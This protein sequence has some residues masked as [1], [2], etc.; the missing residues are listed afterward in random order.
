MMTKLERINLT[1][2]DD[3][4]TWKLDKSGKF[5]TRSMYRYITFAG[6]VDVR[7]MEIWNTKIPLKVKIFLWMAWHD[8]IQTAQ[9]FRRRN[10]DGSKVCKF[11]GKD[12]TVD[13]LLFQCS[14]A[15]VTWCCVRNSL[16]WS[17][18]PS[19]INNFQEVFLD[20]AGGN[21]NRFQW[22]VIAR[23][24]WAIWKTRNKQCSLI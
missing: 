15:V 24:G 22:W 1:E 9:Q 6:V 10:W 11:R 21:K 12:E 23:V 5:S 7:M 2:E 3:R 8:R 20:S 14:I 16:G 4:V 18:S 19:S 13:H 17:R